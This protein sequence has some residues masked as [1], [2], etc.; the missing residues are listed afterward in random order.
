MHC[1][2][3]GKHTIFQNY[4]APKPSFRAQGNQALLFLYGCRNPPPLSE[5]PEEGNRHWIR[6]RV[7]DD[8]KTSLCVLQTLRRTLSKQRLSHW[9]VEAIQLVYSAKCQLLPVNLRAH[10]TRGMTAFLGVI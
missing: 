7:L 3:P 5:P 8:L 9:K 1:I 2:Y 10:S 4:L 6:H